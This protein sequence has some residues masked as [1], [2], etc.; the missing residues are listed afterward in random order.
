MWNHESPEYYASKLPKLY[1]TESVS[2]QDK[3]IHEH[4]FIG[5]CDWFAAEFGLE[6]QLFFGYAILNGDYQMAEWG[7]FSL[8]ELESINVNGFEVDRD[9]FWKPKKASEIEQICLGEGWK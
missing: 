6:E 8:P 3:I 5:N 1:E 9:L 4:L 7:Y 2:P